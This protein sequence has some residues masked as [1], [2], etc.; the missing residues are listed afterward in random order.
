MPYQI[1]VK[2]LLARHVI[3]LDFWK[4]ILKMQVVSPNHGSKYDWN[5]C[6][7]LWEQRVWGGKEYQIKMSKSDHLTKLKKTNMSILRQ[8]DESCN[9]SFQSG[10]N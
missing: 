3:T 1:Q 9:V 8:K 5:L 6:R 10:E 7:H 2:V 4:L